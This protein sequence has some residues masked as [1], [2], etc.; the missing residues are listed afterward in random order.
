M[1]FTHKQLKH[2]AQE[3]QSKSDSDNISALNLK[4]LMSSKE[5]PYLVNSVVQRLGGAIDSQD[6]KY[7]KYYFIQ[8]DRRDIKT[9]IKMMVVDINVVANLCTSYPILKALDNKIDDFGDLNDMSMTQT[10]FSYIVL[11][12]IDLNHRLLMLEAVCPKACELNK[13]LV[14]EAKKLLLI[15]DDKYIVYLKSEIDKK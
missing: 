7:V 12:R 3:Y 15:V 10:A 2:Y 11:L 8:E 13:G 4:G 5:L 1:K 9:V 6:P 14:E